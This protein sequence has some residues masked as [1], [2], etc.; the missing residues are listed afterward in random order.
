MISMNV[1][2]HYWGEA[3]LS[4]AYL[5]N[6]MSSKTLGFTTPHQ[7]L[8]SNYPTTKLT[9]NLSPKIFGCTAFVYTQKP[10]PN[11]LDPR[12][13]KCI[14]L[15]YSPTK[16]G[17]KCY[18]PHE[19]RFCYTMDVTFFEEQAF[20]PKIVFQGESRTKD[21]HQF[22]EITQQPHIVVPEPE[23]ETPDSVLGVRPNKDKELQ[24]YIRKRKKQPADR[25]VEACTPPSEDQISD[26]IS[27]SENSHPGNTPCLDTSSNL[28]DDT[29][30]YN[31]P[32]L[33][34]AL[35][36]GVRSCTQH[37]IGNHVSFGKLS[38]E[39]KAFISTLDSTYTPQNFDEDVKIPEWKAAVEEE[40][41]ALEKNGTWQFSH[42]PQGKKAVGCKWIFSVKYNADGS[43]NR[44]K[45]RLV[46]KGF[47]Q[48]YGVDYEET[49]ASVAKLNSV[50]VLLTLAVNLDWPLHQLDIKNAFLNGELEDVFMRIPPGLETSENSGKVCK[51]KRSLYGLK[52]SPHAWF[53]RLTHVV[54]GHNFSQCQ[55]D[56]TMFVKH[57]VE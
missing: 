55:T 25:E 35:R 28:V 3:V 6:R 34:I 7:A 43:I 14:F 33:P 27:N 10:N 42:L 39:Y 53:Y 21:E 16:K 15:G 56:H 30:I 12:A 8:L 48:S 40:I 44:Y 17:Y 11:K 29:Q 57:T 23:T 54:K 52:Q 45:A 2:S 4:S 50:C 38:Q 13:I 5:I 32:D 49:Y 19:R 31:D 22:L 51:L 47:T 20:Y 41:K 1:P 18:C 26:Q 37:P 36:K 24:V 9:T 46:A